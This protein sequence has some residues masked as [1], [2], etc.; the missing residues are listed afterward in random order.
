[1]TANL[2]EMGIVLQ[3]VKFPS[4][5]HMIIKPSQKQILLIPISL[6]PIRRYASQV[7][8]LEGEFSSPSTTDKSSI[9]EDNLTSEDL[10]FVVKRQ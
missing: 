5:T 3:R 6:L 7:H 10:V 4:H 2:F 9:L 1:M 8:Q